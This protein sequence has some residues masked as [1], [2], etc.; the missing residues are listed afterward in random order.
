M[1]ITT[2]FALWFS[3]TVSKLVPVDPRSGPTT[4]TGT[5]VRT[6][7]DPTNGQTR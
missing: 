4:Y 7:R 3:K 6:G 5:R 1:D 2:L